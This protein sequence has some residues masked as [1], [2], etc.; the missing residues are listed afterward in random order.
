[1]DGPKPAA[2]A[3]PT[4]GRDGHFQQ[5]MSGREKKMRISVMRPPCAL[6]FLPSV[7]IGSQNKGFRFVFLSNAPPS[8]IRGEDPALCVGGGG[9]AWATPAAGTAPESGR[10]ER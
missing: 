1:M 5:K 7:A 4:I 6:H 2:D 3:S 10:R 9:E 8:T